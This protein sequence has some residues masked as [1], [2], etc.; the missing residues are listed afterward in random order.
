MKTMIVPMAAALVLVACAQQQIATCPQAISSGAVDTTATAAITGGILESEGDSR[1]GEPAQKK[2]FCT[3]AIGTV[4]GAPVLYGARHCFRPGS[5][6][7]FV[8]HRYTAGE[9]KPEP[10]ALPQ[11][12]LAEKIKT[13]PAITHPDLKARLREI[14]DG[15]PP[16]TLSGDTAVKKCV[17]KPP[18]ATSACFTGLE[19]T[20]A[21]LRALTGKPMQGV[22][23]RQIAALEALDSFWRARAVSA[24]QAE[25]NR[26][27]SGKVSCDPV[28]L[29][30]GNGAWERYFARTDWTKE[31]TNAH[32][33]AFNGIASVWSTLDERR[34][35]FAVA[36]NFSG[37]NAFGTIP[38][39]VREVGQDVPPSAE[40]TI[41]RWQDNRPYSRTF[42]LRSLVGT[43]VP[44]ALTTGDSGSLLLADGLPV[45]VLSHIDGEETS[46][47]ASVVALP[48]R[49][50]PEGAQEGS[51][52][53][54]ATASREAPPRAAPS[55]Q[56]Q[57]QTPSECVN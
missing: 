55:A 8:F 41:A 54:P 22:A 29:S 16:L 23:S 10:I 43:K 18:G 31:K 47:G 52:R 51:A 14:L 1:L 19:F 12:Q 24:F 28:F 15:G 48:V 56:E 38:L 30:E 20:A 2:L 44:L 11:E 37:T 50:K 4:D 35:R 53:S 40:Q 49:K 33:A 13:D 25:L 6:K 17:E 7:T 42:L 32:S 45:A 34:A 57:P 21:R 3:A 46:G 39:S 27:E 5:Y 26:C 36:G 9:Y